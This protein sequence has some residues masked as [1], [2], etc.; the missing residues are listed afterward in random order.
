MTT[1]LVMM[2]LFKART[3]GPAFSHRTDMR[4]F[5]LLVSQK[6]FTACGKIYGEEM[7]NK[8]LQC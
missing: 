2:S 6:F 1:D 7:R 4:Q 5:Q 3:F 8:Q